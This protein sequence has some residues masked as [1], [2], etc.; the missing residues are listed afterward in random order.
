[1]LQSVNLLCK[2][3]IERAGNRRH[4]VPR[5]AAARREKE[6]RRAMPTRSGTDP[7]GSRAPGSLSRWFGTSGNK[8]GVGSLLR[9]RR[10]LLLKGRFSE[11]EGI[12]VA[13][14]ITRLAKH[15]VS[16]SLFVRYV[17]SYF[18][19]SFAFLGPG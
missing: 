4:L 13:V 15:G 12:E 9:P 8:V 1:M 17:K 14:A 18:R 10:T 16:I 19:I 3:G 5:L 11:A 7:G 6:A 2:I